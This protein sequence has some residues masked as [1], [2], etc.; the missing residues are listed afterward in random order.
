MFSGIERM[1]TRRQCSTCGQ[2]YNIVS[3]PPKVA[4]VCDLD[5]GQLVHREDDKPHLI[6]KRLMVFH[7]LTQPLIAYYRGMGVLKTID[8][9]RD[10]QQV[11]QSIFDVLAPF[12]KK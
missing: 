10:P 2:I 3:L 6:E 7:D 12:E 1:T 5:G 11:G 9:L 4:D 8:G